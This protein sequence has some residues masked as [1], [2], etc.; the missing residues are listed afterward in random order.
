MKDIKAQIYTKLSGDSRIISAVWTDGI[1]AFSD[2]SETMENFQDR[3]PQITYARLGGVPNRIGK[4][5]ETFQISSWAKTGREAE[6]LNNIVVDIF[7]RT[8]TEIYKACNIISVD[9]SYDSETKTKGVHA[10][11][12]FVIHDN[13]Y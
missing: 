11:V 12:R 1:H 7:N 4:R 9:D 6:D 10:T 8:Q 5:I 3:F 13:S 2:D